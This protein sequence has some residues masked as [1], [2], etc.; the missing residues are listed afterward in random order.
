LLPVR[1]VYENFQGKVDL[2][3]NF[4]KMIE[5]AKKLSKGTD[6]IRVDLYNVNGRVIFGELTNYPEAG[7]GR[8]Y[9]PSWDKKFGSCW[10]RW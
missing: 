1:L 6:F 10:K 3:D 2:P 8:F 7:T 5:I 4:D 9:P